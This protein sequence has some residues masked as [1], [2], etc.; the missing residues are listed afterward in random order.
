MLIFMYTCIMHIRTCIFITVLT[1][2]KEFLLR[3]QRED[4]PYI[5]YLTARTAWHYDFHLG[6]DNTKQ[7]DLRVHTQ[8]LCTPQGR[9]SQHTQHMRRVFTELQR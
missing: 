1:G 7:G 4:V 3:T 5:R 2:L 8:L 9:L 6:G